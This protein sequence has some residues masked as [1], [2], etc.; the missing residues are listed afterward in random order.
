MSDLSE[1]LLRFVKV[2]EHYETEKERAQHHYLLHDEE[3]RL[4]RAE[5]NYLDLLT[6]KIEER[7]RE[8]VGKKENNSAD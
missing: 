8:T 4:K 5:N 6:Q 1:A 7:Y 2:A 3:E